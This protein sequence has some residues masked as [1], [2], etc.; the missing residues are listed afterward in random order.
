MAVRGEYDVQPSIV[1]QVYQG[2]VAHVEILQ[3]GNVEPLGD[4]SA[5]AVCIE[6]EASVRGEQDVDPPVVVNITGG[7]PPELS[8][9]PLELHNG[10]GVR[11]V[12]SELAP[13]KSSE[14]LTGLARDTA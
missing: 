4:K 12:E 3:G 7:D 1:V 11:F 5:L 13:V 2:G 10:E 6:R 9:R 8:E 14:E